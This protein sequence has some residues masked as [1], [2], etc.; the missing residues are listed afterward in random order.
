MAVVA[1]IT[2]ARSGVLVHDLPRIIDLATRP[3]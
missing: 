2:V 3:P 1:K